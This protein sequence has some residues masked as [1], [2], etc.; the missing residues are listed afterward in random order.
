MTSLR[1]EVFE[2]AGAG[3]AETVVTDLDTIEEARLAAYEQGYKAGW[4]DAAA[5]QADEQD[6]LRSDVARNL[7]ALGFTYHEAR[8][9]VMGGVE[10]LLRELV[11]HVLPALAERTLG[12]MIVDMLLPLAREAAG[13]PAVMTFNPAI[14]DLVEAAVTAAD[15]LPVQ[16]REEPSLG[17]GQ[18]YLR[19]DGREARLDLDT[20]LRR[21]LEATEEF[22]TLSKQE[23]PHG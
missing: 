22:F 9:H 20:T 13:S 19:L 4:E 7:Q 2:S 8:S 17:E 18:V 12:P 6:R 10:P 3:E 11:G 16:L 14:R 15:G 5:T 21:I 23:T 1:L